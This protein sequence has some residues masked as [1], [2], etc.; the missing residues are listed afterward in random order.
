MSIL[1]MFIP[2]PQPQ[3]SQM[4]DTEICPYCQKEVIQGWA[5]TSPAQSNDCNQNS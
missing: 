4:A 3:G 2:L 5:C 1:A